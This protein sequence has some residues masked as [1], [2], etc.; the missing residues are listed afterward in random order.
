MS[1]AVDLP[2]RI[3]AERESGSPW[4]NFYLVNDGAD[5]IESAE[6]AAVRHEWGE[7][8]MGGESPAVRVIDLAPRGRALLWRDDGS[9]EMRTDLWLRVTHRARHLWLL[10]EFPKLY[11]Q[12]GTMLVAFPTRTETAP[13]GLP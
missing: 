11:R 10:F 5:P 2:C 6:L 9:S 12:A 4:W 3:V 8:Y 13:N 7:T 1:F